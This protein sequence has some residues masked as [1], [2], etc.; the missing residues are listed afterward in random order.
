MQFNNNL[1]WLQIKSTSSHNYF[2][3]KID[4]FTAK[5]RKKDHEENVYQI[6]RKS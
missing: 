3:K 4:L 6:N 5:S 1:N 2:F